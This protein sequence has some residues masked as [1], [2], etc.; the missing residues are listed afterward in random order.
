MHILYGGLWCPGR[1]TGSW[2]APSLTLCIPVYVYYVYYVYVYIVWYIGTYVYF[3]YA[4]ILWW[5]A[6]PGEEDRV[7]V[8]PQ[9]YTVTLYIYI[10][11]CYAFFYIV[12]TCTEYGGLRSLGWRTGSG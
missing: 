11:V 6:V 7:M 1:R 10:Y 9:S 8:S 2:W 3:V 12:C 4:H 5:P